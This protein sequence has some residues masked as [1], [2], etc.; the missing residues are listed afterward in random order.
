MTAS[1][2]ELLLLLS[3]PGLAVGRATS[4]RVLSATN[5]IKQAIQILA[6]CSRV[7]LSACE[8]AL[9]CGRMVLAREATDSRTSAL[10]KLSCSG[11][12]DSVLKRQARACSFSTPGL[13]CRP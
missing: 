9:S 10:S 5:V 6:V 1:S 13:A 11:M 8:V 4:R 12:V 2:A 7:R 3:F